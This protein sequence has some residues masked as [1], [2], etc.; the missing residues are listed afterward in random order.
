MLWET[1]LHNPN[2]NNNNNNNNNMPLYNLLVREYKHPNHKYYADGETDI[3]REGER[4]RE[5]AY[6]HF[7]SLQ[8][9]TRSTE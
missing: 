9:L 5:R 7:I 8:P 6:L 1:V 3:H 2:N 4:E